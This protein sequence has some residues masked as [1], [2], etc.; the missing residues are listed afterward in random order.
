MP[1]LN[2]RELPPEDYY[3]TN[4]RTLVCR[5]V[6]QYGQILSPK[7]TEITTRFFWLNHGALRLLARLA[8]RKGPLYRLDSLHYR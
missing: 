6:Q 4:L 8:M 3:A 2:V 1:E 7:E 5:V